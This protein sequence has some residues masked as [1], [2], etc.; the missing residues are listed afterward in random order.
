M[1]PRAQAPGNARPSTELTVFTP[2]NANSSMDK[3]ILS[4]EGRRIWTVLQVILLAAG[5]V[6][7]GLLQFLPEVG[8]KIM[9][10]VLIPAAP[11][12]VTVAPGLWRNICPM[13]TFGLLPRTFG[14]SLQVI[15]PRKCV[16]VLG[17]LSVVAL[18]LIVPLR[19]VIL[20]TNGPATVIMLVGAA[21]I[22]FTIG[23]VFE[24]RSG[25]CTSLCPIHPVEKLYGTSPAI[26]F[27]NARCGSCQ[28]CTNPCPDSTPGMNP[29][30]TGPTWTET[31]TGRILAGSFFGFVVGWFQVPDYSGPVGWPVN[32]VRRLA[33][34]R[35]RPPADLV[36]TTRSPFRTQS[37][38]AGSWPCSGR[39]LADTHVTRAVRQC[40][41]T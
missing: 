36:Q 9:W 30:I 25:W 1:E 21:A 35:N 38:L 2:G 17:V 13:A 37:R 14:F 31:M 33:W 39:Y 3:R 6:L 16:A 10:D 7:V 20:N 19:H 22:A 11:F 4:P 27:K 23:M 5:V 34:C 41:L 28:Q 18:Y 24:W 40:K 15:M 26:S 8:I 32:K 29:A 12:L